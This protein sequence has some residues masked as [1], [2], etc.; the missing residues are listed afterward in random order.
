MRCSLGARHRLWTD[1]GQCGTNASGLVPINALVITLLPDR[2]LP[3]S[4]PDWDMR[5]GTDKS[6]WLLSTSGLR[7]PGPIPSFRS[8]DPNGYHF[9]SKV[10][11]SGT[12]SSLTFWSMNAKKGPSYLPSKSSLAL[13]TESSPGSI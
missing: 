6:A 7:H 2:R 11:R 1:D 8:D 5:I 9:E 10:L 12:G 3:G 4:N 13:E